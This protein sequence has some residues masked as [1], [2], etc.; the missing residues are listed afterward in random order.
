MIKVQTSLPLLDLQL[1]PLPNLSSVHHHLI[2]TPSLL[3]PA[4]ISDL[5]CGIA[6]LLRMPLRQPWKSA[7]AK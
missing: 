1:L 3:I 4:C 5:R 7:P 6:V 2:V